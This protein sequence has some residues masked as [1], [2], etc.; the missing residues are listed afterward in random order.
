MVL[1]HCD[2]CGEEQEV[3]YCPEYED[4][5]LCA[6][7]FEQYEEETETSWIEQE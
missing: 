1:G 4:K 5:Y 7:C 3:K 6:L 2:E